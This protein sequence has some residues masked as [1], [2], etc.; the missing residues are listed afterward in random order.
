MVRRWVSGMS[1]VVVVATLGCGTT[2]PAEAPCVDTETISAESCRVERLGE[3]R[4][5]SPT[6]GRLGALG[7][8]LPMSDVIAVLG[9]ADEVGEPFEEGATGEIV[10]TYAWKKLGIRIDSARGSGEPTG[11]PAGTSPTTLEYARSIDVSAP[12]PGKTRRGIAIGSSEADVL[13]AY[14]AMIDPMATQAGEKVVA[15]S[16]FGGMIFEI[17]GGRVS[18]I[19]LGAAAE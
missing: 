14:A 7:L 8:G 4:F 18:S 11:D 9:P 19:F 6:L 1:M 5:E 12:F 3:E 13:G 10:T 16:L 2:R 15:G 17:E